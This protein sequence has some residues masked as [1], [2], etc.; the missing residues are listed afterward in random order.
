MLTITSITFLIHFNDLMSYL[1]IAK[2]REQNGF[3]VIQNK[4]Y[5]GMDN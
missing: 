2:R 1:L 3:S 5:T 4:Y